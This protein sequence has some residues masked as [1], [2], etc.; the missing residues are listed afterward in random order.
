MPARTHSS[1]SIT[2]PSTFHTPAHLKYATCM[3]NA[4]PDWLS[5]SHAE[6][7]TKLATTGHCSALIRAT[8]DLGEVYLAHSR[9]NI[10]YSGVDLGIR[11][12]ST[13][14]SCRDD[15]LVVYLGGIYY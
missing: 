9:Y 5:M 14:I 6:F 8:A 11:W 15:V 4:R 13:H 12:V 2:S 7:Y 3:Q 1:V 10:Q